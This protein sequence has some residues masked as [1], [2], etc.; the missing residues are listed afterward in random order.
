MINNTEYAARFTDSDGQAQRIPAWGDKAKIRAA[1]AARYGIDGS[2]V[3]LTL[4]GDATPAAGWSIAGAEMGHGHGVCDN[5][6][7]RG[8]AFART[9]ASGIAGRICGRCNAQPVESLSFA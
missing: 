2:A 9:D 4:V 3:T 8:R 7:G 1:I 6:G 5:C